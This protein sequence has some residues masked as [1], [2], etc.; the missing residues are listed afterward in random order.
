M[1]K[2]EM[3]KFQKVL[4]ARV[5]EL[6]QA[7]GRRDG[8]VIEKCADE[9]ENLF[10]AAQREMAVRSLESGTAKLRETIAAL[11]RIEEGTYGICPECEEEIS[12]K[13]L[14]AGPR[15][16]WLPD[17]VD[18]RTSKRADRRRDSAGDS[19]SPASQNPSQ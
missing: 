18:Q 12:S 9:L 10:G 19:T 4:E 1:T 5:T 17:E 14:L 16:L 7:T 3:N 8:I 13:R 6:S 2:R 15:L 11:R